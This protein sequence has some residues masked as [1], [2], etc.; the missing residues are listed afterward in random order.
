[1]IISSPRRTRP[2]FAAKLHTTF[3]LS[4]ALVVQCIFLVLSRFHHIKQ[5]SASLS[6]FLLLWNTGGNTFLLDREIAWNI[7]SK[8]SKNVAI[9]DFFFKILNFSGYVFV[10]VVVGFIKKMF[11][12]A[13][14]LSFSKAH[15]TQ[16]N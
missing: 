13:S 16:R 4:G 1:M 5:L 7:S 6:F 2:L 9:G 10:I 15:G 12:S 3:L 8:K 14:L 11:F